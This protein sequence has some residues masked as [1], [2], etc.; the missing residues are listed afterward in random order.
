MNADASFLTDL[1]FL[2]R[3]VELFG[4]GL[5]KNAEYAVSL[6]LKLRIVV[7]KNAVPHVFKRPHLGP[8][9]VEIVK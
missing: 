6:I 5:S 7:F 1:H 4:E 9:S 3:V 2:A 8:M